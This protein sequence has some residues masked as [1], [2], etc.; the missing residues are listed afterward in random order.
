M[1]RVTVAQDLGV[2]L[3]PNL[4]QR[5]PS[6]AFLLLYREHSRVSMKEKG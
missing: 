4:R 5:T 3:G 2:D 1:L 6:C